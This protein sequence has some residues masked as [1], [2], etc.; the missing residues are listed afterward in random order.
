MM[1]KVSNLLFIP[2]SSLSK[3]AAYITH[4]G[5]PLPTFPSEINVSLEQRWRVAYW[6]LISLLHST[7]P[8]LFLV[9]NM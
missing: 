4:S 9:S 7:L 5:T 2:Y 6:G 3:P 1:E 8:D